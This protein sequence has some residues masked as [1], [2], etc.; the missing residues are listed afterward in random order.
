[1]LFCISLQNVSK[2]KQ[3]TVH[4]VKQTQHTVNP[5]ITQKLTPSSP[6]PLVHSQCFLLALITVL[7]SLGMSVA[8]S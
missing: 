6:V 2:V 1:M 4:I 7:V 8:V 3:H 5:L